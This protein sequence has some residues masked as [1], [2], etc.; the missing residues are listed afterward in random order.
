M[1]DWN[2]CNFN[3]F[4]NEDVRQA[5]RSLGYFTNYIGANNW[6]VISLIKRSKLITIST[7]GFPTGICCF[8]SG[9]DQRENLDS[10]MINTL[11]NNYFRGTK[12][13]LL[14][15]CLTGQGGASNPSNFVNTLNRKGVK[16]VV[17]FKT[18]TW[19]N[20]WC[21]HPDTDCKD[22]PYGTH[23]VIGDM[24]NQLF[25]RNFNIYLCQHKTVNQAVTKAIED[26][27]T[28]DENGTPFLWG[29]DSFYIAGDANQIIY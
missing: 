28:Y 13:I 1:T 16:T 29:L 15:A 6:G 17:G 8:M 12:C 5:C 27:T 11:P 14:N 20:S 24:G 3:N 4:V 18:E 19:F 10:D 26:A 21:N 9:T 2:G 22:A 23:D 7:H 25:A